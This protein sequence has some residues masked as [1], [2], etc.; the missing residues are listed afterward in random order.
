MSD[1]LGR[2]LTPAGH[3]LMECFGLEI[4]ALISIARLARCSVAPPKASSSAVRTGV[5][6][7]AGGPIGQGPSY[8]G[9]QLGVSLVD[10]MSKSL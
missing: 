1:L 3:P 8:R 6:M 5:W 2:E 4:A 9:V 7:L 10:P